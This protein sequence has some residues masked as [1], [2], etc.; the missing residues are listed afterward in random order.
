MAIRGVRLIEASEGS[1]D[2][3]TTVPASFRLRT[4]SGV[5]RR[6]TICLVAMNCLS[7]PVFQSRMP[8][9]Y[10]KLNPADAAKL[11]ECRYPRLL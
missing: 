1:L 8:Q 2:Y 5:S 4:V 3:F 11:G 7:V 10:I 9:P 6:T